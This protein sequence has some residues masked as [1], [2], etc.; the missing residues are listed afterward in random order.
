MKLE[1]DKLVKQLAP[2]RRVLVAYSGGLDSSVLLHVMAKFANRPFKLIA[3]HINH[4]LHSRETDWVKH[5]Q[6]NCTQL[7]VELII[8]E[9]PKL[10][11]PKV[12]NLEAKL[13]EQ[14]YKIFAQLLTDDDALVTA[15]HAEDQAETL[16]MRL[17]RGAGVK[18]LGAMLDQIKLSSGY[19]LRPLLHCSKAELLTYA[20]QH[21]LSWVEDESNYDCSFDRNY[22]RHTL[23]PLIKKR[24]PGVI[25]AIERSSGHLQEV[26][27]WLEQQAET[28][29]DESNLASSTISLHKIS[30]LS[31]VEQKNLLRFWL[32]K[33]KLPAATKQQLD[34]LLD[35]AF[36][37]RSDAVPL[38]SWPGVEVRRFRK[39]LY[40]MTPLE[41]FDPSFSEYFVQNH[42]V[43][44]GTLGRLEIK[45]V[46]SCIIETQQL[47]VTFRQGGEKIR[48]TGSNHHRTLKN[49]MQEWEIPPWQ[50]N[51]IP[52][53]Y[54]EEEIVAVVG[55]YQTSWL[56][57]T[58]VPPAMTGL[59]ELQAVEAKGCHC[60]E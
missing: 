13:R 29:W 33:L 53:I 11:K 40:A 4:N 18:G 26:D 22:L 47:R 43:L 54:L 6:L 8:R 34:I 24:W 15:H 10:A 31:K 44:P 30:T 39:L 57:C 58:I 37:A 55:Y 28:V 59:G 46:D 42:L 7:G 9:L 5:C 41:P 56:R 36:S 16:L 19:L 60:E 51:R 14:R 38:I 21:Q 12:G 50:R 35:T 49:L 23:M 45:V 3:V 52:I 20:N 48:L 17:F 1:P 2:Y 27:R 25:K 32:R